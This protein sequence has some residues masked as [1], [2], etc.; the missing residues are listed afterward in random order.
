MNNSWVNDSIF[1]ILGFVMLTAMVWG[2]M[3]IFAWWIFALVVI[4]GGVVFHEKMILKQSLKS[5]S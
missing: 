5:I 3:I 1:G 2:L 4:G